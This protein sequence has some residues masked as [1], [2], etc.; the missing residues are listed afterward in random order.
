[1]KHW[2]GCEMTWCIFGF[3]TNILLEAVSISGTYL[4]WIQSAF[5]WTMNWTY[6]FLT[7]LI[8]VTFTNYIILLESLMEES[9]WN[10]MAH[11]DAW[12]GKWRGNWW[13]EWVATLPRNMVYP[14]LLPFIHTPQLPVVDWTDAPADL[15]G[16]ICFAKRRNLVS[17]HVPSHFKC[18]LLSIMLRSLLR[19]LAFTLP[20]VLQEKG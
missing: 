16:L 15:N 18:S 7:I 17:A 8:P 1:M 14:A 9:S 20:V 2:K 5:F 11:S 4:V 6:D 10:V 13:M 19:M 12:E 3:C